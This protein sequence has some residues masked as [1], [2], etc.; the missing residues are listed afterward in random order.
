ME[1]T[2]GSRLKWMMRHQARA[3]VEETREHFFLCLRY[4]CID[5]YVF[6]QFILSDSVGFI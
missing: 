2:I 5:T 1:G 4:L 3:D 6:V